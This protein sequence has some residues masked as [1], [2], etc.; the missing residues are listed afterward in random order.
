M[1]LH[2]SKGL[3]GWWQ[4]LLERKT[5]SVYCEEEL[6]VSTVKRK[7]ECEEQVNGEHWTEQERALV[8]VSK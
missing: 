2:D 5:S 1:E 8:E 6:L 4:L 3:D 7:R